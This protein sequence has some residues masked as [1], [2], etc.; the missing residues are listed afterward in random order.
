MAPFIAQK[1]MN[2][3]ERIRR[4]FLRNGMNEEK[5]SPPSSTASSRATTRERATS[6][7]SMLS[8][9]R[10]SRSK[11]SAIVYHV[12]DAFFARPAPV[13]TG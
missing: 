8:P 4:V 2:A 3:A 11:N 10:C 1:F 13:Y 12:P 9:T 7:W 6:R 5:Q